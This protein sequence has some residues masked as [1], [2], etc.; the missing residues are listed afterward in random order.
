MAEYWYN[1]SHHSTLNSSPFVV[2][3]GHEP[4]HWGIEP[5]EPTAPTDL[6]TWLS[7]RR[8]AHDLLRMHLE[9]AQQLMKRYADKNRTFRQ[10]SVGDLVFLKLQPYIQSSIAPRA[11]H[12]LL[13]KFYG[14]F[15]IIDKINDVAYKLELPEA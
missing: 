12:K 8:V 11:N 3:Y 5:P 9:R 15:K 10:F 6:Q 1:T 7:E 14:P 4:R 13:F 2:L